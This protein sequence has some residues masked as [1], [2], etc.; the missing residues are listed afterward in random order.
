MIS[1]INP[2]ELQTFISSKNIKFISIGQSPP[3]PTSMS[4]G[5]SGGLPSI[6]STTIAAQKAIAQRPSTAIRMWWDCMN[7]GDSVASIRRSMPRLSATIPV[8]SVMPQR[9][10]I[11]GTTVSSAVFRRKTMTADWLRSTPCCSTGRA[12]P[13]PIPCRPRSIC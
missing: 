8:P 9:A 4:L 5:I 13:E 12:M 6:I 7:C 2:N 10:R 1:V 11:C 3:S